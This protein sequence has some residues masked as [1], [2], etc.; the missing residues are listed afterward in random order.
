MGV[1][2]EAGTAYPS[3]TPEFTPWFTVV[4]VLLMVQFFVL[5]N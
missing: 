3:Q 1:L 5:A 2:K 4:F